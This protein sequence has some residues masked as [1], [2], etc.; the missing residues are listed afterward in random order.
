MRGALYV[1]MSA[2]SALA[3]PLFYWAGIMTK[4]VGEAMLALADIAQNTAQKA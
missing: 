4:A 2:A 1:I 3:A